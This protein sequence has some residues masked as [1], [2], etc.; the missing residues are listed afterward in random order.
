MDAIH[1]HKLFFALVK[2]GKLRLGAFITRYETLNFQNIKIRRTKAWYRW[3]IHAHFGSRKGYNHSKDSAAFCLP[4]VR[5]HS[6]PCA[7]KRA[8][9][10][11]LP[12]PHTAIDMPW[13]P[14]KTIQRGMYGIVLTDIV[15]VAVL[16]LS[17]KLH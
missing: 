17:S 1:A 7:S 6:P 14:A 8:R 3:C 9:C 5:C 16:R 11:S 2:Q 15:D 12:L 4:L 10:Y 13:H